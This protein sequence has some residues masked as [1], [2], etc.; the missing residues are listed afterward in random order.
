MRALEV[1]VQNKWSKKTEIA[2]SWS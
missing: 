2:D 1:L